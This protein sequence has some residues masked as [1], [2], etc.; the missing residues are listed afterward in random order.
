LI[1]YSIESIALPK[2]PRQ[3]MSGIGLLSADDLLSA[4]GPYWATAKSTCSWSIPIL[5]AYAFPRQVQ[6]NL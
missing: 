5:P 1:S 2:H 6:C 3:T 4:S